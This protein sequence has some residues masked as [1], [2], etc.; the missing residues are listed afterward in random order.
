M[1]NVSPGSSSTG[2]RLIVASAAPVTRFVAPGP[3]RAR[4]REGAEPVAL[5]GVPGGEV[6][7]RLLVAGLVE[8]EQVGVLLERLAEPGDVAV[9]EDAEAAGEEALRA[10]P[11]R[12][13][14]CAARKRTSAWRR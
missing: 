1:A 12:S 4:A 7:H 10:P 2:R 13:T 5:A 9:A 11:S 8:G 6:H 14:S 3:D